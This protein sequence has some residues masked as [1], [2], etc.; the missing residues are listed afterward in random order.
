MV[1]FMIN[2]NNTTKRQHTMNRTNFERIVSTKKSKDITEQTKGRK[3]NKT[4]RGT[5]QKRDWM[6]EE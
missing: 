4:Q 1:A 5:S 6:T 3:L 2:L